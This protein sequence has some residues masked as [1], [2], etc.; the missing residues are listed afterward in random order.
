MSAL[1]ALRVAPVEP[2]NRARSLFVERPG[3]EP[4]YAIDLGIAPRSPPQTAPMSGARNPSAAS[5]TR[6]PGE[7]STQTVI[8]DRRCGVYDTPELPNGVEPFTPP[9]KRK[10]NRG[11]D[12]NR[13]GTCPLR[14]SR[15]WKA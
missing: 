6:G 5:I 13:S 1:V 11:S 3:I 14:A 8:G 7:C 12:S 15:R 10:P 2:D 9:I 4:S